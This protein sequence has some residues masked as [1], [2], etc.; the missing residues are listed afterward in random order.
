MKPCILIQGF[1][2]NSIE[3]K[4]LLIGNSVFNYLFFHIYIRCPK[5]IFFFS[6]NIPVI[7]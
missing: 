5:N 2:Y 7:S 1:I 4:S 6:I 3:D